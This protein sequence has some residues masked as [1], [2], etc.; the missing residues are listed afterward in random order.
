MQTLEKLGSQI[1]DC[2]K[3]VKTNLEKLLTSRQL[4]GAALAA[5]C[6]AKKT[7]LIRAV[8]NGAKI[9]NNL[10]SGVR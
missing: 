6:V 1:S 10:K 3:D 5:P 7:S 9:F 2:V 8:E 4:F